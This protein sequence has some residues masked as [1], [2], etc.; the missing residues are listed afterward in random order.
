MYKFWNN[1]G[2]SACKYTHSDKYVHLFLLDISSTFKC[3][4][5]SIEMLRAILMYRVSNLSLP[6]YHRRSIKLG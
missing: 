5:N 2:Q 6:K 1:K 4:E 3:T